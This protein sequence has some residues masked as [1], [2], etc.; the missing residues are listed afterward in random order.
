MTC[1]NWSFQYLSRWYAAHTRWD[2]AH[3]FLSVIT[4]YRSFFGWPAKW[5]LTVNFP[6]LELALAT[7]SFCRNVIIHSKFSIY[8]CI[9]EILE[10]ILGYKLVDF[11]DDGYHLGMRADIHILRACS[12][13]AINWKVARHG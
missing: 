3:Q 8:V 10:V 11:A 4:L 12:Y 13:T 2:L 9:S 1:G 5:G 6:R 7:V